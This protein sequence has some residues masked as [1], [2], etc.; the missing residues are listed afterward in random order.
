MGLLIG[1]F[2]RNTHD[3]FHAAIYIGLDAFLRPRQAVNPISSA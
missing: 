1:H 2:N 3:K